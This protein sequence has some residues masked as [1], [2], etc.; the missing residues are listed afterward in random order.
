MLSMTVRRPPVRFSFDWLWKAAVAGLCGSLA[1]SVLM[2]IKARAG[3]LPAFNPYES[4]QLALSGWT[5]RDV[6]S[7]VPWLISYVNGSTVVSFVYGQIHSHLPG[8]NGA[9]RGAVYGFACW[10]AMQLFLFPLIGLGFFA[11]SVD[12][13]IW[14]ALFSLIM[15]L[16]YSMTLGIV[17]ASLGSGHS[18]RNP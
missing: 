12:L 5:G 17:Y 18:S 10:I 4:L 1:H 8:S 3:I 7:F 2:Y 6:P 16:T 14:P 13:G 11:A 9:L 15:L